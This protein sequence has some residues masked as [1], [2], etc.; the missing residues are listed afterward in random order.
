MIT[1][2]QTFLFRLLR[3]GS[4]SE[5]ISLGLQD[6]GLVY[7]SNQSIWSRAAEP[8]VPISHPRNAPGPFYSEYDGCITCGAPNAEAPDL[9]GWYE[10]RCGTETYSHCIFERQPETLDEV[11]RA[12]QAM[13]V[14]C[15][16][17]LRYRGTDPAILQRLAQLGMAHLCDAPKNR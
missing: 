5:P 6:F 12:I 3:L 1:R 4:Q 11:D 15:V 7:Q 10:E 16:E 8:R 17:N 13:H 14:S 2:V 9:I